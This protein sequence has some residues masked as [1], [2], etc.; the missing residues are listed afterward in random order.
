MARDLPT[1][2]FASTADSQWDGAGNWYVA[3]MTLDAPGGCAVYK[4]MPGNTWLEVLRV[5]PPA[6]YYFI[7]FTIAHNGKA[8]L[9]CRNQD[10]SEILGYD[11]PGWILRT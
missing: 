8:K 10:K 11:V 4:Y 1:E 2:Y 6:G 5:P 9:L 3:C 7:A